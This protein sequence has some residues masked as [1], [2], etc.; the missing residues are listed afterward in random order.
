MTWKHKVTRTQRFFGAIA[1]WI[2]AL[3]SMCGLIASYGQCE[4]MRICPDAGTTADDVAMLVL[5]AAVLAIAAAALF[6]N[7]WLYVG[8]RND[9]LLDNSN[10]TLLTYLGGRFDP[11]EAAMNLRLQNED[12]PSSIRRRPRS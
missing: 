7:Y 9:L 3:G 5:I 12:A 1:I 6:A 2:I 4:A 8:R 11:A 10:T